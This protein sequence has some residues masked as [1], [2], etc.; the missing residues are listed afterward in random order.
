M[1]DDEPE[2]IRGGDRG[3]D[4]DCGSS[5]N[6]G[7]L[8]EIVDLS[9]EEDESVIKD[10]VA[11]S[12]NAK[13]LEGQRVKLKLIGAR[14][15]TRIKQRDLPE[16]QILKA[17]ASDFNEMELK[18]MV[19]KQKA[20]DEDPES[21]YFPSEDRVEAKRKQLESMAK[22]L[23]GINQHVQRVHGSDGKMLNTMVKYRKQIAEIEAETEAGRRVLDDEREAIDDVLGKEGADEMANDELMEEARRA[24]I[25]VDAI[26]NA[27][28][29]INNDESAEANAETEST[30]AP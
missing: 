12:K 24:G 20:E 10:M 18:D 21:I 26:M 22:I 28:F 19:A 17:L 1:A 30:D 5:G 6:D 9:I 8:G 7:H 14:S 3:D 25:D 27:D 23:G 11:I 16:I 29:S 13:R 15:D 4:S 2:L